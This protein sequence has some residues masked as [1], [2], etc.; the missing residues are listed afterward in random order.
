MDTEVMFSSKTGE[1]ETPQD[2][3]NKLDDEFRFEI[4]VCA[5]RMN[6]KCTEF[7]SLERNGL[8][9]AW[10]GKCWMNPPYGRGIGAWV[11][12]AYDSSLTGSTVVCLL[13]SRTD[14]TWCM[15]IV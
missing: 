8:L 1:W 6:A 5:T 9:P 3:F 4:D 14:T 12:K 7:Y 10:T 2:F 15:T 11:K 13:P